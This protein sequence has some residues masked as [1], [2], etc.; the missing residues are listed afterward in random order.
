VSGT[1]ILNAAGFSANTLISA[2]YKLHGVKPGEEIK[3]ET[4]IKSFRNYPSLYTRL[5]AIRKTMRY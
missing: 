2:L 4:D 3:D 1:K 5:Q